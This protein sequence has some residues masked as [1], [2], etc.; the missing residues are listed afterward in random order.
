[1][2]NIKN[3]AVSWTEEVNGGKKP[4]GNEF[5]RLSPGPNKIRV[6]T[7]AY[8]YAQHRYLPLNGRKFGYRVNCSKSDTCDECPLCDIPDNKPKKRWLLGVIERST[9]MYK[10]LDIGWSVFSAIQA[11]AQSDWGDPGQYDLEVVVNPS[12]GAL[13][14]YKVLPCKEKALSAADILMKEENAATGEL[15]RRS[16]APTFEKVQARLKK[17]AEE[18]AASNPKV[19]AEET[20]AQEASGDEGE[21]DSYFP[22]YDQKQKTKF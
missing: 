9:G 22:N 13:G 19:Q 3:G 12:G 21:G 8:Q 17:I 15:D 20:P 14:F 10:I 4:S 1:M 6:L 18:I 16:A 2:A 7:P 11:L 5:L